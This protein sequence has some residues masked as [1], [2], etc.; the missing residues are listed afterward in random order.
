MQQFV[1]SMVEEPFQ[2]VDVIVQHGEQST[3]AVPLEEIHL[4]LLEMVVGLQPQAVLRALG[5]IA[6]ED[7]VEVFE[8]RFR[9][10]HQ[11]GQHCQRDQLAGHRGGAQLGEPGSVLFHHHVNG[12]SDQH[13]WGQI[14]HLVD[15]GA[16]C[17]KP[18]PP[19]VGPQVLKQ[20]LQR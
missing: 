2:L 17:S 13:R 3:G 10:P 1:G 8:Q 12:Q 19:S 18:D 15:H 14:K 9:C 6:P 16:G 20:S 7:S 11:K 5:Q 4:Q